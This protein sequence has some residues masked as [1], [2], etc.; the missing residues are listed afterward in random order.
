MN[1]KGIID[2]PAVQKRPDLDDERIRHYTR[3][4]IEKGLHSLMPPVLL[5][6]L[7][8]FALP[9]GLIAKI[10]MLATDSRAFFSDGFKSCGKVTS[11]SSR[12]IS[13][14]I[15]VALVNT[16]RPKTLSCGLASNIVENRQVTENW[17]VMK[18]KFGKI[19]GKHGKKSW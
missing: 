8:Y 1:I 12:Q 16:F 19:G 14:T 15:I 2:T 10:S 11:D 7:F 4:L 13:T 9:F 17:Y 18:E 3:F 6:L 5:H